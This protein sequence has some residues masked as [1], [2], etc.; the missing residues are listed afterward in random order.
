MSWLWL[1]SPLELANTFL[2]SAL[3]RALRNLLFFWSVSLRT[4]ED[5]LALSAGFHSLLAPAYPYFDAKSA[6]RLLSLRVVLLARSLLT[7]L[8]SDMKEAVELLP[9]CDRSAPKRLAPPP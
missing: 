9:N 1:L 6:R 8:E 3:R 4:T 7:L 2:E 5:E